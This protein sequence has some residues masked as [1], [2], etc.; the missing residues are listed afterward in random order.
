[1]VNQRRVL[2]RLKERGWRER[3]KVLVGGAPVTAKWA[4]EIGAD[5]YGENAT[6]AVRAALKALGKA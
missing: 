3:F 6:A 2:I 5:G 1:M 4:E